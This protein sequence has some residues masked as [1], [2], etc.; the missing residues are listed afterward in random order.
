MFHSCQSWF[1]NDGRAVGLNQRRGSIKRLCERNLQRETCSWI[2]E[3]ASQ[4]ETLE[5]E[6]QRRL[7]L[8]F[9]KEQF[10]IFKKNV[11]KRAIGNTSKFVNILILKGKEVRLANLEGGIIFVNSE[12]PAFPDLIRSRWLQSRKSFFS[13]K[14]QFFLKQHSSLFLEQF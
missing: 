13:A 12:S 7:E 14:L 9:S 11:I 3:L 10:I 2:G 4:T 5:F 8:S 6:S 1:S